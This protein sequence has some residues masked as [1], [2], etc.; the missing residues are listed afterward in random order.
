MKKDY[1]LFIDSGIGGLT[2]LSESVK[3]L[4]ANYIYYADNI[5]APYGDH[6]KNEIFS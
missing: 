3:L 6:T 2:T 5:N 4:K 1:V